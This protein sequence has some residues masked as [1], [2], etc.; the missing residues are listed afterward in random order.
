MLK[1]HFLLT[2]T[3]TTDINTIFFVC[4]FIL[5]DGHETLALAAERPAVNV[6][7]F[8]KD[9]HTYTQSDSNNSSLVIQFN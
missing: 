3:E 4:E 5:C 1:A 2:A 6:V 7:H 8:G 9:T